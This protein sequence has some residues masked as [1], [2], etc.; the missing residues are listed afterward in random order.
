V[1]GLVARHFLD[2]GEFLWGVVGPF[3]AGGK[4]TLIAADRGAQTIAGTA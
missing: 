3:G 2:R 1:K 4:S